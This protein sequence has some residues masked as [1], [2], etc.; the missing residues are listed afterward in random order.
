MRTYDSAVSRVERSLGPWLPGL[1][2]RFVFASV[3][4]FYFWNSARTKVGEGVTGFFTVT[5]NAYYQIALPAVE[6]AG[7]DVSQVGFLP[8]GLMVWAGTYAEFALPLLIVVGLWTRIAALGMAAFIVVQSVVDI[9]AHMVGSETAGSMFDRFSDGLIYDQRLLW[10]FVLAFLVLHGAG[11]ISLD[12]IL[13][14]RRENG[15]LSGA[16][17]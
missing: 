10:L 16:V 7:G 1:L 11:R 12:A 13:V 14:R 15:A 17:S 8:W 5:D 6:A 3:L 4:L 2:A 9:V